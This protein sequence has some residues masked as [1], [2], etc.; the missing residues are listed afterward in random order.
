[1][2]QNVVTN[3]KFQARQIVVSLDIR[4][5]ATAYLDGYEIHDDY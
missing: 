1:M 4:D 3:G 5:R 2:S